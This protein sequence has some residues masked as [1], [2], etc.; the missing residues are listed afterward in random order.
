MDAI[1][2]LLTRRSGVSK[3]MTQPGPGPDALERILMAGIQVPDHR[4][5][6]PWRIQIVDEEGQPVL[7]QLLGRA[8]FAQYPDASSEAV[9]AEARRACRSPLLLVV[10][11]R[12]QDDGRTPPI[13][14]LMSCGAMCQNL[15]NAAHASG[16]VAQWL[17]GWPAYD[18]T[19]KSAFGV[20]V[21][22]HIVGWIH[23]GSAR[24]ELAPRQ[25]ASVSDVVSDWNGWPSV[26]RHVGQ[27]L[28]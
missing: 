3:A 15:L 24:G 6:S 16:F 13:E 11:S 7:A 1:E 2:M 25:R 19:V 14:Q 20:G 12:L 22:D 4:R 26:R 18:L 8:Y 17:T 23:I 10:S 28:I 21:D 27:R 5:L 9:E